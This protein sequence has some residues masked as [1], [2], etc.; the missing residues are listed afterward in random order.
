[1]EGKF[2]DSPFTQNITLYDGLDRIDL[3][4]SLDWKG[5]KEIRLVLCY[6]IGLRDSHLT[7]EVPFGC[8]EYGKEHPGWVKIH[9]SIRGVRN[10]IE[11]WNEEL[12]VTLA[13]QVIPNDFKDRTDNP[14][15]GF[16]IQPILLRTV[17]SCGDRDL[18]FTQEGTY[19]FRFAL[20]SHDGPIQP[21]QSAR[22]GWEHNNPLIPLVIENKERKGL[23]PE[24]MS[25]CQMT[26]PN[27]IMSSL[28]RSENGRGIILRCYET[29]G[30]QATGK[31]ETFRPVKE[32]F[33]TNI[34]EEDQRK[35]PVYENATEFPIEGYSIETF[36]LLFR[37]FENEVTRQD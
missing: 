7:Y 16:M 20:R 4:T 31:I 32:A 5:R 37:H 3:E 27:V 14:L 22:F 30:E 29:R 18:Y 6:P 19:K 23:L 26:P 9:P 2:L 34:I 24:S 21:D 1:M 28:K 25:F 12:G 8:V 10:W 15:S 36:R 11:V 33:L 35:L 13:T 17:F